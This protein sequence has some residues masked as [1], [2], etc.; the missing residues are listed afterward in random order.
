MDL[1]HYFGVLMNIA[2]VALTFGLAVFVHEF[3]HFIFARLRGVGVEKFAI[4]MGPV[5]TSWTWGE[6][7]YSLRWLPLGGFVKLHQIMREEAEP[8]EGAAEGEAAPTAVGDHI[9][10][11][12]LGFVNAV[13]HHHEHPELAA[14]AAGATSGPAKPRSLGEMAH[15]DAV[16]LYNKGLV[17]KLLVFGGGVFFNFL[18]AIAATALLY[19][20]G[21]NQLAPHEIWVG[22]LAK[23]SPMR[24]AGVLPDDKIVEVEGS[25]ENLKTDEDL[26]VAMQAAWE[27]GLTADGV[28]V[29]VNRGGEELPLHLPAIPSGETD[30]SKAAR[31]AFW[32]DLPLDFAPIIG[33]LIPMDPAA[34]AGIKEGD[35]IVKVNDKP[36]RSWEQ[37]ATVIRSSPEQAVMLGIQRE[38]VAAPINIAVVPKDDKNN[39]GVGMIGIIPGPK[40]HVQDP[41]LKAVALAPQRTVMGLVRLV[42]ANYNAIRNSTAAGLK[43]GMAG[44]V[45]IATVTYNFA[46]KG[47]SDLLY[48]FISLNLILAVMNLM[49][50]PVLDGGFIVLAFIEA[51]IRRPVS[52]RILTPIYTFFALSFITLMVLVSFQ[53]VKRSLF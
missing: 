40:E 21:V 17:T 23:E 32:K 34:K 13:T 46:Q 2:A 19:S 12:D 43:E 36:V 15:D 38:G 42:Q 49:P 48:W 31:V 52:Q 16:A 3:G 35:L 8:L 33:A 47:F 39:P 1:G 44:P 51:I 29:R 4:G 5:I 50:I 26:A 7:E 24:A 45:A 18:T 9:D 41:V 20:I 27:K 25:T 6:T 28:D 37:M 11:V 10:E 22:D 53:D 30:E 14:A